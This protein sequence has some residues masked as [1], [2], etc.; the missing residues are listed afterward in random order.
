[1]SLSLL[2]SLNGIGVEVGN[3][4]GVNDDVGDAHL[5]RINSKELADA[6]LEHRKDGVAI[7][8]HDG[9]QLEDKQRLA[10]VV[11]GLDE[12]A[13]GLDQLICAGDEHLRRVNSEELADALLE[14]WED[15]VA[16]GPNAKHICAM[17]EAGDSCW[18]GQAV[19]RRRATLAGWEGYRGRLGGSLATL[20][21]RTD[22]LV[23]TDQHLKKKKKEMD[24]SVAKI[25]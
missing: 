21:R 8:P 22:V 15:G 10:L 3:G 19:S 25:E 24:G 23:L 17:T 5:R 2:S 12:Q 20:A 7:R 16:V 1:M 13:D 14:N 11:C 9:D 18:G 4:T 6:L